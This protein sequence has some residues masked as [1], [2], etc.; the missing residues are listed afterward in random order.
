M[1]AKI[2]IE[3]KI[4]NFMF[5]FFNKYSNQIN[6]YLF[7]LPAFSNNKLIWNF[8]CIFWNVY[9]LY[10]NGRFL[11]EDFLVL[12]ITKKLLVILVHFGFLLQ[13]LLI[14]ILILLGLVRV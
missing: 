14:L 11:R 5:S 7:I 10:I 6:G 13:D 2:S 8:S 12:K 3:D 9:E 4:N 1:M